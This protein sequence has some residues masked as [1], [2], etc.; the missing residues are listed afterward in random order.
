MNSTA[1]RTRLSLF[2][3][4]SFVFICLL[5][6][7]LVHLNQDIDEHTHDDD[8]GQRNDG[9]EHGGVVEEVDNIHIYGF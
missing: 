7:F 8:I 9:G 6:L 4:V 2:D 5:F 1:A 3:K